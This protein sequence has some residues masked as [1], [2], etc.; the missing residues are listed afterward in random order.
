MFWLSVAIGV[1]LAV[2]FVSAFYCFEGGMF[3]PTIPKDFRDWRIRHIVYSTTIVIILLAIGGTV[4]A[5]VLVF[6]LIYFPSRAI[7]NFLKRGW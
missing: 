5:S 7:F 2:G 3:Q 4:L 6:G 1:Y